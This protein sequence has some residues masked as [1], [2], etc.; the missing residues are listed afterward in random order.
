MRLRPMH[1]FRARFRT[2]FPGRSR[3]RPRSRLPVLPTLITLGNGTCGLVSIAVLTTAQP[4]LGQSTATFYAAVLIYLGM[5]LDSMDGYV[6]RVSKQTSEFGVQ[7][8]SLCDAITFGIAPVFIMLNLS[9]VFY[10]RFLWSI[11]VIFSLCVLLRLARYNVEAHEGESHGFFRGLP[12]PAAAGTVASF[13]IA[14][15]SLLRMSD[16]SM[17]HLLQEAGQ[18]AIDVIVYGTPLVTLLL[19]CLMVSRIRYPHLLHQ[20]LHG[21]RNFYSLA[22]LMFAIVAVVTFHEL[23]LDRKSV[24]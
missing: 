21:R 9:H 2:R 20:L 4:Q 17:P 24:V 22:Q 12:S 11:G 10:Q 7:L 3:A 14:M 19:A 6:A 13:G 8:D 15:P 23:A 1:A 18:W 16:P 5:L